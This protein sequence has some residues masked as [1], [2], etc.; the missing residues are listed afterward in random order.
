MPTK[1][2]PPFLKLLTHFF[3]RADESI[4]Y[5]EYSTDREGSV[6]GVQIS[7]QSMLAHARSLCLALN[8]KEG[9]TL[10][11]VLDFKREAGLWH[12]CI[13]AIYAGMRVIFVPYSLLKINPTCWLLQATQQVCFKKIFLERAMMPKRRN[14]K[15]LET[16]KMSKNKKHN[17]RLKNIILTCFLEVGISSFGMTALFINF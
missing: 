1:I 15:P 5:I 2:P 12:S 9:Q 13:A 14:T 6:R 3:Y 16:A 11:C 17:W 8:Y 4:A 7:R 10:I